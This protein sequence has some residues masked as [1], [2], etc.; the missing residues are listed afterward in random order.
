MSRKAAQKVG[1]TPVDPASGDPFYHLRDNLYLVLTP[2]ADN[3][4]PSAIESSFPQDVLNQKING[5]SF[6]PKKK[7]GDETTFG[8]YVFAEQIVRPGV[9]KIDFSG[10]EPILD[11]IS[12]AV[13]HH[14]AKLSAT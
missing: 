4:E 10:F 7:D 1:G 6:D 8:K 9:G 14:Q 3:G 13:A 5:K 2:L 12:K 11:G